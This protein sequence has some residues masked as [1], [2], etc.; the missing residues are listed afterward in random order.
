VTDQLTFF[1]ADSRNDAVEAGVM[2]RPFRNSRKRMRV[3]ANHP[4][5]THNFVNAWNRPVQVSRTVFQVQA[6][7]ACKVFK[8]DMLNPSEASSA[9]EPRPPLPVPRDQNGI[10]VDQNVGGVSGDQAAPVVAPGEPCDRAFRKRADA[11]ELERVQ[12][13]PVL[14]KVTNG[15]VPWV[16]IVDQSETANHGSE[17]NTLLVVPVKKPA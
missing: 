16:V 5:P 6:D 14:D 1:D 3:G 2:L 15:E 12:T 9:F 13:M 7:S 4:S 17:N 8:I 10:S 11:I